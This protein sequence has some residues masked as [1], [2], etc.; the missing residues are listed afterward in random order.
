MSFR[1]SVWQTAPPGSKKCCPADCWQWSSAPPKNRT[2]EN[3]P[4]LSVLGMSLSILNSLWC[5][6][7]VYS[8]AATSAAAGECICHAESADINTIVILGTRI[9]FSSILYLLHWTI[10]NFLLPELGSETKSSAGA[11][12]RSLD[13][14]L[15]LFLVSFLYLK[16]WV[17]FS[18]LV[19]RPVCFSSLQKLK[20]VSE[21]CLTILFLVSSVSVQVGQQPV[22]GGACFLQKVSEPH[23]RTL[24]CGKRR[25]KKKSA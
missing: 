3:C 5:H 21:A 4:N 17:G 16:Y 11:L 12:N 20:Q 6:K 1:S 22:G 15:F 14:C 25:K 23:T 13:D 2:Q 9:L 10:L 24:W 19:V 7:L 18:I 8:S